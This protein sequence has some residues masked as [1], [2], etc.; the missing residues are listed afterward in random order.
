MTLQERD[1]QGAWNQVTLAK[2]VELAA[3]EPALVDFDLD[4]PR[5]RLTGRVRIEDRGGRP[6]MQGAVMSAELFAVSST[7]SPYSTDLVS[8]RPLA[9]WSLEVGQAW[10]IPIAPEGTRLAL[11]LWNAEALP[12]F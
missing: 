10:T 11:Q 12:V 9:R 1:S 7:W 4:A 5:R 2:T 8:E 3:N 6:Q